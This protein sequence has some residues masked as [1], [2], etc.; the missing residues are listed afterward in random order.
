MGQWPIRPVG[1]FRSRM[2]Y[3][4]AAGVIGRGQDAT[5]A[6]TGSFWPYTSDSRSYANEQKPPM[7]SPTGLRSVVL[8][9]SVACLQSTTPCGL[10][11]E[12]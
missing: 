10:T 2:P 7:P 12:D 1:Y 5:P 11:S 3:V 9:A 4:E 8:G 6:L